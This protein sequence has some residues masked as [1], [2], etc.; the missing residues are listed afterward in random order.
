MKNKRVL[1]A[2]VGLPVLGAAVWSGGW[3]LIVLVAAASI[4]GMREFFFFFFR[5]GPVLET[6]AYVLGAAC[7]TCLGFQLWPGV[8]G[9][10]AL[11]L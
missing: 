4:L 7:V 9:L 11:A 2:A 3:P 1:T 6:V 5:P 10:L 8:I